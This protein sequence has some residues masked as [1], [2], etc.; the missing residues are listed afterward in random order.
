[1]RPGERAEARHP[2]HGVGAPASSTTHGY[3][4]SAITNATASAAVSWWAVH[5]HVTPFL[6]TSG[7]WPMAG[8]PAWCSLPDE[9]PRKLAA[10]LDAARHWV[11]RVETG[12]EAAAQASQ[13]ISAAADWSAVA[14]RIRAGRGAY[15]PRKVVAL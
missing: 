12:Q 14:D 8:T 1:V 7:S 11:L 13:A 4:E 5:E 2:G 9:D 3:R 15:I 10:L 6:E